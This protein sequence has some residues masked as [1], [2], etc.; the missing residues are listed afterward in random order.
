[1]AGEVGH[2]LGVKAM[3]GSKSEEGALSR[4]VGLGG[5]FVCLPFR[6]PSGAPVM[7]GVCFD[8]PGK[9]EVNHS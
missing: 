6:A 9:R 3:A 5:A 2:S 8:G 4:G 1:M 7:K